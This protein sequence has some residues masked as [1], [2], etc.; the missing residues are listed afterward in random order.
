[1]IEKIACH[2]EQLTLFLI[3]QI[4][5]SADHSN[6]LFDK[7]FLQRLGIAACEFESDMHIGGME[8]LDHLMTL[9]MG[10]FHEMVIVQPGDKRATD[11]RLQNHCHRRC[12]PR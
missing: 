10:L 2:D 9:G 11:K 5:H 6:A 7:S 3:R 1:M 12:F 4:R 8:Y